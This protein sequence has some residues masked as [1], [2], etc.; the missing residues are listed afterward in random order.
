MGLRLVLDLSSG[1]GRHVSEAGE[2]FEQDVILL[3][4]RHD[5]KGCSLPCGL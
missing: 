4:K 1:L 5:G 3:C 2:L